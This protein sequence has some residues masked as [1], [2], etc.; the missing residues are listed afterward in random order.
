MNLQP[1]EKR[2]DDGAN[3]VVHSMFATVQGEGPFTGQPALFVRLAGCNL[4]CPLCDTDYTS[5]RMVFPTAGLVAQIMRMH[6]N[7]AGNLVVLTGGEPFRQP[8]YQLCDQLALNG[9]RVQIE[10]NGTLWRPEFRNAHRNVYIV[11]SPKAGRIHPGLYPHIDALKYVMHADSVDPTDGLPVLALDH[12]N[13]GRVA[14]PGNEWDMR[15]ESIY[16][17]PI[18]VGDP[19]ENKRHTDAVVKSCMRYGYTVCLQTHK[20]LG[21]E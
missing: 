1:I 7:I 16:L 2:V 9:F 19:V 12:P 5:S 18:D 20:L 21:V 17:Q 15:R 13:N 11:C 8:I 6:S 4:Q 10:T 3:I 14:R